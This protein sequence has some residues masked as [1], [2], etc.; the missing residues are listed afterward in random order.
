MQLPHLN[1]SHRVTSRRGSRLIRYEWQLTEVRRPTHEGLEAASCQTES[2]EKNQDEP[3]RPFSFD[4]NHEPNPQNLEPIE[5][6][7]H[8]P[9]GG[10][11]SSG[12]PHEGSVDPISG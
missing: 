8:L 11:R 3:Q 9:G 12:M 5:R 4:S 2:G 10:L 7:G 6:L 1:A